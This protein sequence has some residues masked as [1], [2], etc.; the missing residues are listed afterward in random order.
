[1]IEADLLQALFDKEEKSDC[2]VN[3][4][5]CIKKLPR[6]QLALIPNTVQICQLL[7]VNSAT[8]TT[9]ER[10]FSAARMKTWMRSKIFPTSF[11]S[12]SIHH[13]HKT[14]TDDLS[15]TDI[16]NEFCDKLQS[17]CSI[18]GRFDKV[19]LHAS[20]IISNHVH[21]ISFFAHFF[22]FIYC[23]TSSHYFAY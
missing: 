15:L 10:S 3:K 20:L 18:F 6:S 8:T 4:L 16:A 13:T 14:L 11:N 23:N 21:K 7:L 19:H 5:T 22:L 1:M 12:L 17:R 9:A 2:F